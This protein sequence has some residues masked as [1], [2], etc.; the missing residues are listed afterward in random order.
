MTPD[1]VYIPYLFISQILDGA[2]P[3]SVDLEGRKELQRC[4]KA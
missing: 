1:F 2:M 3:G 4:I